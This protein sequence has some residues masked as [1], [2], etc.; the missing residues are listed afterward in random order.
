VTPLPAALG[1]GTELV[2]SR[3][4]KTVHAPGWDSGEG[5]FRGGGRWN[6]KG[7]RTVYCSFD[8]ATTI[9][10][11]AAHK[12]FDTLD[13]VPHTLTSLVLLD[14]ASVYIVTPSQIPNSNWLRPGTPSGGQQ[15]YG[16]EM[17]ERHPFVA[18]P[19]VVSQNSWN[20]LFISERAKGAYRLETQE[21]FA[22][23]TRLSPPAT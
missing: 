20:L 7:V 12:G 2:A 6:S 4:D 15:R 13:R 11:S 9:L 3:L 1:G 19:S 17:L 8:P 23:D 21:P 5:A 14:P 22:P 18:I 16:D 10:E